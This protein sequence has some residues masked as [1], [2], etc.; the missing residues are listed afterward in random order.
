MPLSPKEIRDIIDRSPGWGAAWANLCIELM[1]R[2]DAVSRRL[3]PYLAVP[4]D[5]DTRQDFVAEIL[6]YHAGRAA[7][8]TVLA[9]YHAAKGD[10]PVVYLSDFGWLLGRA[11]DFLADWGPK[12]RIDEDEHARVLAQG[13]RAGCPGIMSGRVIADLQRELEG[14]VAKLPAN[15]EVPRILETAGLQL[16]RRL[17]WSREGVQRLRRHLNTEIPVPPS[18]WFDRFQFLQNLHEQ[19]EQKY[20]RRVEELSKERY[21]DGK[22]VNPKRDGDL[23]K[24]L[25]ETEFERAFLPLSAKSLMT[26]LDIT[27]DDALARRSRYRLD[28]L[29]TAVPGLVKLHKRAQDREEMGDDG[30]FDQEGG[31]RP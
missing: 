16:Y 21:N 3:T 5:D 8:G 30:S 12:P 13:R 15:R 9:N 20:E 7:R 10:N 14:R 11:H 17:D 28:W 31:D 23:R 22:G 25:L 29:L 1:Q 26:L 4:W 27:Q 24:A 19:E 2:L 18:P 6:A